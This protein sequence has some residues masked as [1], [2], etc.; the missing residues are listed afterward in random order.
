MKKGS[1]KLEGQE[2]TNKKLP[3]ISGVMVQRF[4]MKTPTRS[5]VS[6]SAEVSKLKS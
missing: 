2:E 4:I 3:G 1:G 6:S 5:T